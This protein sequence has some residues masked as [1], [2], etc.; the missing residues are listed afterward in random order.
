MASAFS[1]LN[2]IEN[3][4][5]ALGRQVAG[6]NYPPTNKNTLIRALT[7]EWD[8]LS[9]Q[10]LDNVVQSFSNGGYPKMSWWSAVQSRRH[11]V[12]TWFRVFICLRLKPVWCPALWTTA[13]TN[14]KAHE[15]ASHSLIQDQ[16]THD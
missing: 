7:E 4:W 12:L 3:V 11:N 16:A 10:L 2:L 15:R 9:Q 1:D 13:K 5:D 8:K 6:Q 14:T